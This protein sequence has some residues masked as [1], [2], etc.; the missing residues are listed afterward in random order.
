MPLAGCRSADRTSIS[1]RYWF[2]SDLRLW[3]ILVRGARNSVVPTLQSSSWQRVGSVALS[4]SADSR[5]RSFVNMLHPYAVLRVLAACKNNLDA[6]V[7]CQY[8][9][10]M[11]A[12]WASERPQLMRSR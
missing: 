8:G 7:E 11:G 12:G 2:D 5:G 1:W 3:S 6:D 4:A 10:L 9:P